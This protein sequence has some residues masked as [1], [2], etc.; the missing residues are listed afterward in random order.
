M[1]TVLPLV[2]M[3]R[4]VKVVGGQIKDL[5]EAAHP[6]TSGRFLIANP[7]APPARDLRFTAISYGVCTR[8]VESA[9]GCAKCNSTALA[10]A[11]S[12]PPFFVPAYHCYAH[13]L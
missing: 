13:C 3:A 12:K 11:R 5:M 9:K 8:P 7:A 4:P 2:M 10:D 6:G 1:L